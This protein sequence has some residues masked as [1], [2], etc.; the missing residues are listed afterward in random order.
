LTGLATSTSPRMHIRSTRAFCLGNGPRTDSGR[1]AGL[2]WR[3]DLRST[4]QTLLSD[5]AAL[6]LY[7]SEK[8]KGKATCVPGPD[9]GKIPLSIGIERQIRAK[10][11]RFSSIR[12]PSGKSSQGIWFK[13]GIGCVGTPGFLLKDV[14]REGISRTLG[15]SGYSS[16]WLMRADIIDAARTKTADKTTHPT[17]N[18]MII[19]P[20]IFLP[21][22]R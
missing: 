1:K 16:R 15:A 3:S 12:N 11:G 17:I 4:A 8:I 14:D 2:G 7:L 9:G 6:I 19:N 21:S 13:P 5:N 20:V 18:P 22:F 10:I